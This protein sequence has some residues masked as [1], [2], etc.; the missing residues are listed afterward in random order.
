MWCVGNWHWEQERKAKIRW[1]YK[2]LHINIYKGQV[3]SCLALRLLCT[4]HSAGLRTLTLR[5]CSNPLRLLRNL[6]RVTAE[7]L[8]VR[9]GIVIQFKL[10][11]WRNCYW[12]KRIIELLFYFNELCAL[13]YNNIQFRVFQPV[14]T[15]KLLNKIETLRE[16]LQITNRVLIKS[17]F[18]NSK[19]MENKNIS[20]YF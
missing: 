14:S 11:I 17:F 9:C 7:K 20:S 2:L 6:T 16:R 19:T 3:V 18:I 1:V 15:A 4:L 13:F 10:K 12:M 5:S 8:R